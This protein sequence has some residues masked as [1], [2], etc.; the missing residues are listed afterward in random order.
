MS[1]PLV[2]DAAYAFVDHARSL[3]WA[4][5]SAEAKLAAKTFLHDSLCVGVAGAGAPQADAVLKVVQGWGRGED[6]SV[7][8]HPDLRLPAASAAF[9]NAFQIHCQEFDAVHEP[10]VLHPL[11]TVVAVLRAESERSGPY[12]GEALLTAL[13]VGVDVAVS[14]G[15]AV[16]SP[17]KFFRPATAGT[18]GSIAAL[19]SLKKLDRAVALDAL[20]QGL[21]F[22]SGT[23]QAHVEGKITLPLQVGAAARSALVAVELAQAGLGGPQASI[24]GPFGYLTLFETAFDLGPILCDLKSVRRITQVSWKAFPTGRAAQGGLPALYALIGDRGVTADNLDSLVF[25][26]PPLIKRLV[27]RPAKTGM[28]VAY[29]RLCLAWLS[30]VALRHGEVQLSD[31]TAERLNDPDILALAARIR[32]EE[33]GSTDPAA[34]T[35]LIATATL[36]TGEVVVETINAM[37]G[38]PD[39]P[40]TRQQHLDKARACLVFGGLAAWHEPLIAAIETLD[41]ALNA[42]AAL[43][44]PT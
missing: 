33:D 44:L 17:L 5:V 38:S 21:A 31:F 7:L 14:L 37:I 40:L 22:A 2:E 23:M 20:G 29:G 9:I 42:A 35:P 4:D 18:F 12:S 13:V 28:S 41:Q 19:I 25:R 11:A 39:F 30:A 43:A 10:A 26:A 15:V 27:G 3:T 8:G 16:T 32:V 36:K 6:C 34:F 24:N 1:A